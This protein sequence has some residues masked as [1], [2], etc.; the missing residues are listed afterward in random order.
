MTLS[1]TMSRTEKG[2]RIGQRIEEFKNVIT[3]LENSIKRR[4]DT[5]VTLKRETEKYCKACKETER[6]RRELE[7][8]NATCNEVEAK[9]EFMYRR[10]QTRIGKIRETLLNEIVDVESEL[11]E[12]KEERNKTVKKAG[13]TICLRDAY[14][15]NIQKLTIELS[16]DTEYVKQ[17]IGLHKKEYNKFNKALH[18]YIAVC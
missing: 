11:L 1:L 12:L 10:K 15:K 9:L 17:D 2:I 5:F 7:K 4:E 3:Q 13:E 14:Y 18:N 8:M 16:S 6:L